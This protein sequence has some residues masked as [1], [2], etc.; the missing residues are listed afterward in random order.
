MGQISRFFLGLVLIIS[1]LVLGSNRAIFWAMNGLIVACGLLFF[2][3]AEWH[4]LK[5]SVS[6]WTLPAQ[7]LYLYTLP[8]VWML[9]QIVPGMPDWLAH[10]VWWGVPHALPTISINPAQ[11]TLALLWWLAMGVAFVAMRA[12]TRRGGI[13][14]FL[15]LMLGVT[16]LVAL[17]GMANIYFEL[18][19]VG[20]VNKAYYEGWLT[21]TFVN[22][23]SAASFFTIGLAIATVKL[24]E[25][26][27]ELRKKTSGSGFLTWLFLLLSS[28]AAIYVGVACVL[29]IAILLTGSRAGLGSAII[30]IVAAVVLASLGQKKLKLKTPLLLFVGLVVLAIS[31]NSILER[32][33]GAGSS[34]ARIDL[35]TEAVHAIIER[36]ITGHGAGAYQS[37]EPL[38]RGSGLI[39]EAIWNK[40]H[41]S[42]LEAMVDLGLPFTILWL[43][44]FA[45]LAFGMFRSLLIDKKI[46][47]ATVVFL[48]IIFAEGLHGL[49]D[50]SFQIQAI[51][52]YAATLLGLAVGET[53][54]A[55]N[56]SPRR[57]I[58][59]F[60]TD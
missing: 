20:L 8:V 4:N 16:T 39:D 14:Y 51:A 23:N 15:N 40:A 5:R 18:D 30:A 37:V 43:A 46:R 33:N 13:K 29:I 48:S 49:V 10:P 36:P 52:I 57:I 50:F 21:G 45:R 53:M 59:T 6:D 7:V 1:P 55:E 26:I 12:G 17:F 34:W 60:K 38:Y 42:Y 47:P 32:A 56:E 2:V 28:R 19:S 44:L 54:T 25:A 3:L 27:Q 58:T 11:T 35:A 9:V 22:R 31:S 24:L 41:N